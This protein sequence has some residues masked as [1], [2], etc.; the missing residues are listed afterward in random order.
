MDISETTLSA[1]LKE[2][3]DQF[4]LEIMRFIKL[5]EPHTVSW[6]FGEEINLHG[7]F[8]EDARL[9]CKALFWFSKTHVLLGL[10][11]E[12]IAELKKQGSSESLILAGHLVALGEDWANGYIGSR[13][14]FDGF[15]GLEKVSG[16]I[17][18]YKMIRILGAE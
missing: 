12:V 6:D 16:G 14:F 8:K 18:I 9:A 4:T 15:E 10:I 5:C 13:R 17:D 3:D 1:V 11:T 2:A 7:F